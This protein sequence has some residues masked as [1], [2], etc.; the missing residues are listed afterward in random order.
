MAQPAALRTLNADL[1]ALR[2]NAGL[3]QEDLADAL[4]ELAQRRFGRRVEITKKTVGR[5]E[6]GEVAWPQ[7]FHRR[8]LGEY[9]QVVVDELGFRRPR[10]AAPDL[11]WSISASPDDLLT[12]AAAPDQPDPRVEKDQQQWR[13]VRDTLG[14]CRQPLAVLAEQ[15]YPDHR[16]PGLEQTGVIT[17]PTWLP[18]E[19][20]PLGQ[21][22]LGRVDDAPPPAVSGSERKS[23]AVRPLVSAERR[24][25]RYSQA[26][27]DLASPRLFENRLCFRL[28]GIDWSRPAVQLDFGAMGFFDAIDTNE[29]LAHETALHHLTR[30]ARGE[31]ALTKPSWRRLVFRKLVGD[32]FDLARR[33]LMGAVGTLTIRADE[34]P[35]VVLH[36]RDGANVAGGGGMIHLLPAGIFQPSSV[37]PESVAN[38][39]SLWR[40]VQ[41]EYAEELLG[42]DEYDGTGAPINYSNTEPF[43]TMDDAL[44]SGALRV[45]CLGVTLDALTLAADILTVAVIEPDLYDQL[46][47]DAVDSN[48]EGTIPTHAVPFEANT[49]DQLRHAGCLTPGAAAALH[50]AWQHRGQL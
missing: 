11:H 17:H 8:L 26:V 35:C 19:P 31:M 47:A 14:Q 22:V 28:L 7:P 1:V 25:R 20:I 10:P 4:N 33:P 2:E 29:A 9:F 43:A 32:P 5:W 37:M 16:M 21:V 45:Y 12:L 44:A 40:N 6:R 42:H 18:A 46:F 15:L 48:T 13:D 34:S 41:R 50:L 23:A 49:L 3:S 24:Y 30:D 36:K 27:R 39:F 38:D